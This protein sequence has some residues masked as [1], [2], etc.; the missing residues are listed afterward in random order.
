[1][2]ITDGSSL[3]FRALFE[4]VPGLY[5]VLTPDLT[6]IAASEAYLQATKT[7]RPE[8]LGRS[9]FEVF[10]DNPADATATGTTNLRASLHRVLEQ[11]TTDTMAVQKYDIR[12]PDADG[13]GFVER[14]WS[15]VNTPV[16]A[17]NGMVSAIIHRVE[18]VTDFIR[19]Q[20]EQQQRHQV[21]EMLRER[22][23]AME[24][25]IYRRSQDIAQ[26][27]RDLRQEIDR[28]QAIQTQLEQESQKLH[29]TNDALVALQ[30]SRDMLANMI[31]HDLRN[32]LTASIGCLDMLS[33][34]L[35][36]RASD[37]AHY[38]QGALDVNMIMMDMINGI[39][40]VM[41]MEDERMPV[42][43]LPTDI[44][45]LVAEKLRQYQPT[46][47]KNGLTLTYSGPNQ[48][49]FITDG[50][51][52]S[53]VVDNLV[54]NAIKHTPSGGAITV[55]AK[56]GDQPGDLVVE[57]CD[58]GEGIAPADCARLFQKYGRVE[59]QKMGRRY[60]TGLGLVFCRMAM[61]LL[62]GDIAV[63]SELGRGSTF[64]ITL[65]NPQPIT[66]A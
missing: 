18:D 33:L 53:R 29:M 41:R 7:L 36:T 9:I 21:T 65:K 22:A 19:L 56:S 14:Y 4:A 25:E 10:P 60:D 2:T 38:A 58:T 42:Q 15:P 31:I 1:M 11:Q 26:A 59:G 61:D 17:A 27:N 50:I 28:R 43:I 13:G 52:L 57:V 37:L 34:K 49:P 6:I 39:L 20:A 66:P 16:F 48:L 30:H 23:S 24:S 47:A 12:L 45:S 3:D 32:P 5:L 44:A 40:D 35:Q 63:V 8:I 54:V 62:Q 55:A 64:T 51:L 46:A